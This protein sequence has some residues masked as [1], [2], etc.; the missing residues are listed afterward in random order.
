M[1]FFINYLSP[2]SWCIR[3]NF[4]NSYMEATQNFEHFYLVINIIV[5]HSGVPLPFHDA[6]T[7]FRWAVVV[8]YA[9]PRMSFLSAHTGKTSLNDQL[10]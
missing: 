1:N 6:V 4:F 3:W 9:L 10:Y 8:I 7:I 2:V 5:G